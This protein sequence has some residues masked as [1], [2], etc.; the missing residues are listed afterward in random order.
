MSLFGALSIGASSLA[1]QQTGLQV[2]GNNIANAGTPGYT[3]QV[4]NLAPGESQQITPGQYLGTGVNV[5]SVQRQVDESINESLR[6]ATSNQSAAQNLNTLLGQ[7]QTTFGALND[8]DISAQMTSFFNSFSTLAN[9]PTDM[10]QR[11]VVVQNGASLAGYLQGLRGQLSAIGGTVQSQIGTQVSQANSLLQSVANL[12]QQIASTG[13]ENDNS[14][15][16]QRDQD[17]SQLS[18]IMNIQTYDQGNGTVNVQ[19]GSTPLVQGVTAQQLNSTQ[20]LDST[21]K[22]ATTQLTIASNGNSL[23]V[24]GGT[25]GSMMAS[26]SQVITPAIQA[27]DSV[28]AGLI[29][30]VNSIHTQGQGLS[31]FSTVTGTTAVADPT[32]ALNAPTQTTNIA[33]PPQNGAFNLYIQDNTTG[34]VTT[35]Q[36]NVNLS[37]QGTQ[38]SLNSLAASITAAGGGVINAS[39]NANGTLS[40]ASNNNNVTFGFGEDS[41]GVLASLGVN[42]FFTGTDATNIAVNSVVSNDPSMLAAGRGNV[43]ASNTNAQALSL[44]GSAAVKQLGGK[45]LTDFYSDYISGLATQGKAASDNA[46]AQTTIQQS[47]QAQ[48][49]AISGVSMDEEAV[50]LTKYQRAYEGSA[51]YINIV[52][53]LMQT[54]LGMVG[55]V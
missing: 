16:D 44:A 28:A 50:N 49:Q 37:G 42:T 31:G 35:Q 29:S 22:Y 3:R 39:V 54:L 7:V 47:L 30:A 14:L 51:Q 38:T 10:A 46:T 41:S 27:V 34:Q 55:T 17:L 36:I 45:S 25:L 6:S 53:Q 4:T 5:T 2:T 19:V 12:N 52:N 9:N 18:Q 32:A 26:Q 21:G 23:V 8:N 20:T 13:S 33:F 40:I 15:L 48:Q 11:A 43:P 1:A 24:N